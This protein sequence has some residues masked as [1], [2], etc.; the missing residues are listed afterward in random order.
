MIVADVELDGKVSGRITWGRG[1]KR[2]S[3]SSIQYGSW[4]DSERLIRIHPK[5]DSARVPGYFVRYIV[6]HEMLHAIVIKGGRVHH[7]R[8]F[9]QR[10]QAYPDYK[11]ALAWQKKNLHIFIR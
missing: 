4:S 8:E 10:E 2:R 1:P 3:R 6:F 7:N 9:R 5:L 11:R